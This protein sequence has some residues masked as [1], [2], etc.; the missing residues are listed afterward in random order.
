[1]RIAI[2]FIWVLATNI[3]GAAASPGQEAAASG[4]KSTVAAVEWETLYR[5]GETMYHKGD[6]LAALGVLEKAHQVALAEFGEPHRRTASTLSATG[7]VLGKLGRHAEAERFKRRAL[8]MQ[9]DLGLGEHPE[10]ADNAEQVGHLL[11]AQGRHAESV[12]LFRR[13][14]AGRWQ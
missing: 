12:P 1:M 8:A 7:D 2:I 3:A 10:A 4:G 6:Y 9:D 14:V 13:A 11:Q 5:S